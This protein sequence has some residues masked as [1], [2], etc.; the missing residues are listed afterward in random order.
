VARRRRVVQPSCRMR[1]TFHGAFIVLRRQRRRDTVFSM[2][3][4]APTPDSAS[5]DIRAS[6]PTLTLIPNKC[7]SAQIL[8]TK[9]VATDKY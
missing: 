9:L 6:Q 1:C 4:C 3:G 7:T 2:M 8:F 5:S